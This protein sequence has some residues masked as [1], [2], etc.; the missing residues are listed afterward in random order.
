VA[1]ARLLGDED[2]AQAALR[3]MERC[4]TTGDRWPERP[5]QAGVQSIGIHMLMRWAMPLRSADLLQ[6]G[7]EPPVGPI[8]EV[9]WPDALVLSARSSD[10][11][12]LDL[13][14]EPGANGPAVELSFSALQPDHPYRL[15]GQGLVLELRSDGGGRSRARLELSGPMSLRL[16]ADGAP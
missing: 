1:G 2:L 13:R 16:D 9:S 6:R 10:G 4:C 7:Y 12:S 14:L 5:L 11:R 15:T 3:G 8:V